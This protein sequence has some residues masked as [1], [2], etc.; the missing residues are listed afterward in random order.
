MWRE[1]L[2]LMTKKIIAQRAWYVNQNDARKK[3]S[4]VSNEHVVLPLAHR[5]TGVAGHRDDE[6]T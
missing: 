2:T 6:T 1:Q 5:R 4:F 3:L